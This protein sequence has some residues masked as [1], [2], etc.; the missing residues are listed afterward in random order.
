MIAALKQYGTNYAKLTVKR[1]LVRYAV[2]G[3]L[4]VVGFAYKMMTGD[5]LP[6]DADAPASPPA[7]SAS[8]ICWPRRSPAACS[9][10]RSR[11]APT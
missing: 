7:A 2:L 9:I 4:V 11:R 6:S 5:S 8:S 3:V 1:Q 10:G